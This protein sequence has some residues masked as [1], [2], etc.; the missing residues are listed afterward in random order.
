MKTIDSL[1]TI[2]GD[3]IDKMEQAVDEINK[4]MPSSNLDDE[5]RLIA[6]RASLQA[7]INNQ[8]IVRAH[9]RAS[10]VVV[11]FDPADE[12]ALDSLNNQMDRFIVSGLA[13]GAMLSLV[14]TLIDTAIGIGN[15]I[16]SHTG[17]G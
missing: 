10:V 2:N 6:R 1:R 5:A 17:A 7:Q 13:V 4:L 9:L 12:T 16:T 15:S 11:D 14:P 3:A 8:A